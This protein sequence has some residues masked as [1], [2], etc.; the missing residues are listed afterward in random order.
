MRCV[1]VVCLARRK[2]VIPRNST[3]VQ[4]QL[5]IRRGSDCLRKIIARSGSLS[6]H[7][8]SASYSIVQHPSI[9]Q[10]I[11]KTSS[12]FK[13][14]HWVSFCTYCSQILPI[15]QRDVQLSLTETTTCNPAVLPLHFLLDPEHMDELSWG[16]YG[17]PRRSTLIL[18]LV[19]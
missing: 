8:C 11:S 1:N 18:G 19:R 13:P 9:S 15:G 7:S 6:L 17:D 14:V 5:S 12:R 4:Q 3:L 10:S 16:Y 2:P